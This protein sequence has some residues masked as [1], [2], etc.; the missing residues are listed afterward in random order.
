MAKLYNEKPNRKYQWHAIYTRMNHEKTIE[1]E[2]LEK[3]IEVYLPKKRVLHQW[4]DRK[5]WIEEPLF[6]PYLFVHVSPKE[7]QKV[8][9]VPAV[10]SYI[11]FGGKAAVIPSAQIDLIK[12]LV[13]EQYSLEITSHPIE[14]GQKIKI[15][16]GTLKGFSGEVFEC[17]NR[18]KVQVYIEVLSCAIIFELDHNHIIAL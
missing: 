1:N 5:R 18:H 6:R 14:N 10:I 9:E 4:S 11:S 15:T 7:Y 3:N 16:H 8:L 17:K 2:L 13:Q 12:I